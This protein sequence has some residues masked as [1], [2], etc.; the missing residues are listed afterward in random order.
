MKKLLSTILCVVLL[1]INLTC[2]AETVKPVSVS[3]APSPLE[4]KLL[5]KQYSA[6]CVTYVNNGQTPLLI[7]NI[8]N[9]NLIG[10]VNKMH[11]AFRYSKLY[12]TLAG[13]GLVTFG[14]TMIVATP[15][16]MRDLSNM[17]KAGNEAAKYANVTQ[18]RS[19]NEVLMPQQEIKFYV[20]VPLNQTPIMTAVFENTKTH[21]YI[22]VDTPK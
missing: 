7:N 11:D 14:L 19:K 20:L 22:S 18:I 6:Y 8:R 2:L 15:I 13:L 21:E 1:S 9:E 10:D 3:T 4:S 16:A 5:N 12:Y 17:K